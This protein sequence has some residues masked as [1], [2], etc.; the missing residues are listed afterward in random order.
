MPAVNKTAGVQ[1]SL[2]LKLQ[3]DMHSQQLQPHH[4]FDTGHLVLPHTE[5]V[6][7]E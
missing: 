6:L 2:R 5:K 4:N 3:S 1:P 7:A